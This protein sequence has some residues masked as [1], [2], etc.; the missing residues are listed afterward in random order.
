MLLLS[1]TY[2]Q[3]SSQDKERTPFINVNVQLSFILSND[4][5]REGHSGFS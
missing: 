5:L 1:D 3:V 2:K 4:M